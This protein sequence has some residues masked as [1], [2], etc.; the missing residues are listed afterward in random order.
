MSE[1]KYKIIIDH[2]EKG[3]GFT[4]R[5]ALQNYS[6]VVA[7]VTAVQNPIMVPVGANPNTMVGSSGVGGIAGDANH[8][9]SGVVVMR[10]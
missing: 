7:P 4:A 10:A 9:V 3:I 8:P 2:K 6:N 5:T 1:L